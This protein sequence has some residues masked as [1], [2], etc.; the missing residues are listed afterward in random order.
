MTCMMAEHSAL[1]RICVCEALR[2]LRIFPLIGRSAWK[3]ELRAAFAVPSAE[4]PST[5]K[6]SEMSSLPGKQS[7][8]FAGIAEVS[9]MFLRRV[10]SFA[11]WAL[12]RACISLTIFSRSGMRWSRSFFLSVLR[13]L[14]MVWSVRSAMT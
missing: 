10:I 14:L 5:I 9:M 6:S 1:L 2:T 11:W 3:V 13:M 8:S 12:S 7:E 4:S